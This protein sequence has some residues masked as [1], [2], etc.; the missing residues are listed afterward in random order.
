MVGGTGVTRLLLRRGLGC[1]VAAVAD[2]D[3]LVS[4]YGSSI[5]GL[6][7]L[8]P[9]VTAPS[10]HHFGLTNQYTDASTV[11]EI[12]R[13]VTAGAGPVQFETYDGA[14]PLRSYFLPR[15]SLSGTDRL[16]GSSDTP[17]VRLH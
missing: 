14:A 10:L 5:P 11:A 17:C 9:R 2:L 1:H 3:V 7:E 6:L 12:R 15:R 8:A 4:Y 16:P 13:A